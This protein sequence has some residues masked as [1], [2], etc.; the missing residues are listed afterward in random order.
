MKRIFSKV[1]IQT[2]YA[3]RGDEGLEAAQHRA[4]QAT[5]NPDVAPYDAVLLDLHL[6]DTDGIIVCNKLR[7]NPLTENLPIL[8]ITSASDAERHVAALDAG[9]DDFVSKPPNQKVLL[10][11]LATMI[12]QRRNAFQNQLLMEQLERYIS[13]ATVSRVQK[14]TDTESIKAAILFSDMRGFT[15]ASYDNDNEEVFEAINLAMSFQSEIV[16]KHKGYVDGFSGDGMLAVFDAPTCCSDACKAA[17]DII[18]TARDTSVRIWDPLP[19][20]IGLNYGLVIRGD[21]EAGAGAGHVLE[22]HTL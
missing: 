3:G 13:S 6:P 17:V 16:Q 7:S 4:L 11:R 8:V 15:A 12:L 14:Q 19:I 10:R 9:A 18:K 1:G 20:G 21:L 22:A 5:N 2:D